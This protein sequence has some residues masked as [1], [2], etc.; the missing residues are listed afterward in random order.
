MANPRNLGYSIE[1]GGIFIANFSKIKERGK[2]VRKRKKLNSCQ[3]ITRA[4]EKEPSVQS[5]GRTRAV[6][7]QEMHLPKPGNWPYMSEQY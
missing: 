7:V 5:A 4:D 1:Y 2:I 3:K 6:Q